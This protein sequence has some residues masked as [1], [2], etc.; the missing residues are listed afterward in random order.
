MFSGQRNL[1]TQQLLV[2][3]E[4]CLR[5]TR[6]EKSHDYRDANVF[7]SFRLRDVFCKNENPTFSNFSGLRTV[8]TK[9]K[10]FC[11]R[12]GPCG[13]S[14]SLQGLLESTKK[15]RGSHAFFRDT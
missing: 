10:G 13:R 6:E 4:L 2:I 12:L 9:Y 15:N 5:K 8:P 3:L 7:E 11:A 14:R 1:K